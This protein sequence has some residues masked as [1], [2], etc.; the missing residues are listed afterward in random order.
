MGVIQHAGHKRVSQGPLGN[1]L[2]AA[3]A[4][5]P[6]PSSSQSVVAQFGMEYLESTIAN[7]MKKLMYKYAF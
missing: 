7:S 5:I 6:R 3:Q 4:D 2:N 1:K